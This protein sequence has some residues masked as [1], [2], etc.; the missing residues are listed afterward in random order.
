MISIALLGLLLLQAPASNSAS[1]ATPIAS[2]TAGA[3]QRAGARA[4]ENAEVGTGDAAGERIQYVMSE[5]V[6]KGFTQAEA[7][8][9]FKDRR[10][11][12]LPPQKVAPRTIDWDQV[13]RTL[14]APPS[15]RQGSEFITRYQDTFRQVEAKYGVD[16][17]L[18]TA[19]LRLES[20]LGKNTGNY[21]A[22]NVF[23]TLLSQQEEE[24]RWRWAG[25]NL[26]ALASFCKNTG[27][28]CFALRGSYA[29]ALGAAQFL[30][31]S[32]QQFGADG[33]G[34][35]RVDPFLMEDAIMS[36]ANYLVIHGWHEDQTAA[37]GKYYGTSQGYARAVFAYAEALKAAQ[38]DAQ[39]A[40]T[41]RQ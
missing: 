4:A 26:V 19:L 34:D 10:L 31:Y 18:L 23:Y 28:D 16:T 13:I 2:T 9:L 37:L 21:V 33:N 11:E 27:S 39:T 6:A 40:Q 12:L 3:G 17:N 22:V 24:K 32:V 38:A 41:P 15:V 5:L 35:D 1:R 20:N 7:E 29:G 14:V 8:A 25:D 30:P 36:A